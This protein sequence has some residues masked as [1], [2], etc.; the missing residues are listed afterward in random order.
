MCSRRSTWPPRRRHAAAYHPELVPQT[1]PGRRRG[2]RRRPRRRTVSTAARSCA[3]SRPPSRSS[4]RSRLRDPLARRLRL[5]AR[6]DRAERRALAAA[7]APGSRRLP[8]RRHRPAHPQTR[9]GRRLRA[10]RPRQH[11]RLR[12]CPTKSKSASASADGRRGR[13]T[14]IRVGEAVAS[15]DDFQLFRYEFKHVAGDMTS[16]WSAATTASA[17]CICKSSTGRS[18]S[19]GT[20]MRL[21]GLSWPRAAPAARHRRHANSRRHA[22]RAPRRVHQ[23]AHRRPHSQLEGQ[24][25]QRRSTFADRPQQKLRLGLRHAHGRR[26]AHRQRDRYRRRRLPRAVSRFARRRAGRTAASRRAARRHRHGDHARCRRCR[27]RQNHRRL[28]PRPRL[29][30]VPGRCRPVPRGRSPSSRAASRRSTSSTRS[31]PARSIQPP[32]NGRSN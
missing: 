7:R 1:Q 22:A 6:A 9:P 10:A 12:R 11:R 16:T 4:L 30:R 14:M 19:H 2:D 13:D 31:T 5:L 18:S 28:W 26:R 32:A 8:A 25:R 23:A 29:V 24:A 3:R 20:G 17:T 15:R 27:C 21:P